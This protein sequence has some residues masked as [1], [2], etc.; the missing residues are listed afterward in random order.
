MVSKAKSQP[1][2][3]LCASL[4]PQV[5]VQGFSQ[6]RD[7]Q[8]GSGWAASDFPAGAKSDS[9]GTETSCREV[10]CFFGFGGTVTHR[11][12][13]ALSTASCERGLEQGD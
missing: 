6:L 13:A 7:S 2:G 9:V 12:G 1:C 3:L 11:T 5:A 4:K 8:S 10:S